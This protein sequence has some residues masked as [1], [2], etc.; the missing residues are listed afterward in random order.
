MTVT[1]KRT[2][3]RLSL[4]IMVATWLWLPGCGDKYQGSLSLTEFIRVLA[5][6]KPVP[7][8]TLIVSGESITVDDLLDM[9]LEYLGEIIK[10]DEFCKTVNKS[11]RTQAQFEEAVHPAVEKTMRDRIWNILLY[12]KAKGELGGGEKLDEAMAKASQRQWREFVVENGGNDA[13]AHQALRDMNMNQDQFME[14]KKKDTL[15][16]VYVGSKLP[17]DSPISHS[18]LITYY[19]EMKDSRFLI[20]PNI[21]MRLIDIQPAR[22]QLDD[23]L[24]DPVQEAQAQAQALRERIEGGEDITSLA[25]THSHGVLARTGGLWKDRDPD[26]LAAPYDL[27]AKAAETMEVGSLVGPIEAPGHVFLMQLEDKR[28]RGYQP[29]ATVQQEVEDQ[30]H[31][32]RQQAVMVE[33]YAEIAERAQVGNTDQFMQYAVEEIYR[34][35]KR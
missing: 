34:R 1:T 8:T 4:L 35:R 16:Q 25:Q 33:L 15:R 32:D 24:A 20:K 31:A 17:Q 12:E 28:I 13:L 29:L 10:L 9:H 22:L 3:Q 11:V 19:N 7:P 26:S 27:L 2:W 14:L 18:E 6:K 21:T 23:P 5:R 30:I